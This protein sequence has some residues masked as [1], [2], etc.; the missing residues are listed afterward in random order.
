MEKDITFNEQQ[1]EYLKWL[2]EEEL[3]NP[4]Q[5]S[6]TSKVIIQGILQKLDKVYGSI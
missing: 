2:C 4:A 3:D 5:Q 1:V 6:K